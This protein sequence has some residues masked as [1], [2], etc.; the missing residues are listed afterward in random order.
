MDGIQAKRELTEDD[1]EFWIEFEAELMA[2]EN[3]DSEARSHLDAGF[4]IYTCEEDTPAGCVIK[5]H[6]DGR[7]QIVRHSRDYDEVVSEL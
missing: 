7:M 5:T 4:P 1:P 2:L 3:D 6:P